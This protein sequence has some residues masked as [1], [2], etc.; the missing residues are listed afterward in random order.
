MEKET[1]LRNISREEQKGLNH[2]LDREDEGKG[3]EGALMSYLSTRKSIRP[4]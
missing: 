4:R 1:T 3:K 2:G